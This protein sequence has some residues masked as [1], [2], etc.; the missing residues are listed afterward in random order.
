MEEGVIVKIASGSRDTTSPDLHLHELGD[1]GRVGGLTDYFRGILKG[2]RLRGKR[3]ALG[4]VVE[5]NGS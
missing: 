4:A 2:D 1:S 3:E 5:A